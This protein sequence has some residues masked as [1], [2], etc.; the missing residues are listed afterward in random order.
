MGV[1][2]GHGGSVIRVIRT[3]TAGECRLTTVVSA[4]DR[5][6]GMYVVAPLSIDVTWRRRAL[7]ID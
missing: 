2:H 1:R 4:A 6:E 3:M 5:L 7:W